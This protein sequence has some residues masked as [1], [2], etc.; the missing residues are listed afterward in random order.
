MN[1]HSR[2]ISPE[3]LEALDTGIL[4]GLTALLRSSRAEAR[5][6]LTA[7]RGKYLNV[8]YRGHSLYKIEEQ[9]KGYK[10]TFNF[11]HARYTEDYESKLAALQE[12]GFRL[13]QRKASQISKLQLPTEKENSPNNELTFYIGKDERVSETF[14]E[15]SRSILTGLIDDFFSEKKSE[16]YFRKAAGLAENG[17]KK[18]AEEKR[19][20]QQIALANRCCTDGICIYDIEYTEP[21]QSS[22]D[23]SPG[24]FD[25]L[26]VRVDS[27]SRAVNLLLIELKCTAEACTNKKSGVEKHRAD[28]DA[29][30]KR[31]EELTT[32]C[33]DAARILEAFNL[34]GILPGMID[35]SSLDADAVEFLFLLTDEASRCLSDDSRQIDRASGSCCEKTDSGIIVPAMEEP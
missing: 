35:C 7:F 10:V 27:R 21:R 30:C 24:R 32:R 33:R 3:F 4:S 14:W 1:S 34:L 17:R 16:D 13:P 9:E 12:L 26:A 11:N 18:I 31:R 6:L 22:T 23:A 20:Q 2:M 28:M 8:Y 25:M 15:D 29:Y 19:R 5:A